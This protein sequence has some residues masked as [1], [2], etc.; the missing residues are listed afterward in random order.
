MFLT[1]TEDNMEKISSLKH[2][3]VTVFLSNFAFNVVT[4]AITDITM[5][6][7]CPSQDKCSLAI[8]LSGF[9]QAIMG[10][11]SM[12]LMPLIGNLSDVYGRKALLTIPVTL[13]IFP[14]V[15]M[16]YRRTTNY[17]YAYYVIRTL[18]GMISDTGIQCI[19]I[20]YAVDCMSEENRASAIATVAGVGSAAF[21]CST[22]LVRF[23]S[24]AQIFLVSSLSSSAAVLYM[25]IFLKDT[26]R[27]INKINYDALNQPI[28]PNDDN[29]SESDS[30]EGTPSPKNIPSFY[31]IIS[32]LKSSTTL[33][34]ATFI[35]FLY[36]LGEGGIQT[37]FLYFLRARFQY[38]KDNFSILMLICYGGT[39]F[40]QLVLLPKLA[41]IVREETILSLALIAG[42]SNMLIDSIAWEA[43]VPY[44]V[45]LFPMFLF[46]AKPALQSIVSKQVGPNEQGIAQG[47][48]S[49]V[50]SFANI[51]S[52]FIFSPLT[53]LFLSERAPFNYPG[54]SMFCI[55]LAWL[56]AIIPSMMISWFGTSNSRHIIRDVLC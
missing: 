24:T 15:I 32:L 35:S 3:F 20:A 19:P 10:L 36:G 5:D 45:A 56:L 11:G 55:G 28:L 9:Q 18:T 14:S 17:F 50:S 7:I 39:T 6:A 30:S 40:S 48:I 49:G 38:N 34:L 43:W 16:A 25:T 42:F 33:L 44:V 22:F 41:R 1:K 2:L 29:K 26:T 4:P 37:P 54:F 53:D 13:L 12:L 31:H 46:L 51:L 8:Y 47:C 23:L 21:L 27:H 52:P